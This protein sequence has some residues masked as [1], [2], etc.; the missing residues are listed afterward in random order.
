[1]R[2]WEQL[3]EEVLRDDA[4]GAAAYIRLALEENDG[5]SFLQAVS[6]VYTARGT[7]KGL[8]LTA[9]ELKAALNA[10]VAAVVPTDVEGT[11]ALKEALEAFITARA[12]RQTRKTAG[13]RAV[14]RARA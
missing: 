1:M 11:F 14:A 13:K 6:N 10:L 7:L 8:D 2:T 9:D 12:A 5:P 4:E 3:R